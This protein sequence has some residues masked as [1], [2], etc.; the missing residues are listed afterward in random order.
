MMERASP[1]RICRGSSRLSSPPRRR[2]AP[3]AIAEAIVE[4]V[5]GP[6]QRSTSRGDWAALST[7]ERLRADDSLRTGKGAS[8]DLR[9]GN[10]ARLTVTES[11]QLTIREITDKLHR[12]EL[13]R[14]RV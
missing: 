13:S 3:A 2:A 5:S 1:R 11:S 8:T 9:I 12:F 6:V 10:Q 14:G 4:A 7:G